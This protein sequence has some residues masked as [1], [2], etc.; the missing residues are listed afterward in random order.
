[1]RAC[2]QGCASPGG[3]TASVRTEGR[4]YQCVLARAPVLLS[5]DC[6]QDTHLSCARE[7]ERETAESVE[8]AVGRARDGADKD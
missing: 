6:W 8:L 5:L 3:A 7:R 4:E 2:V 1:M